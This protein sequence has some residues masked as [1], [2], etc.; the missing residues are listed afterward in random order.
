MLLFITFT[1]LL[2]FFLTTI[3][4]CRHWQSQAAALHQ[5]VQTKKKFGTVIKLFFISG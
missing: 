1:T 3:S 4:L 5:Q 2:L